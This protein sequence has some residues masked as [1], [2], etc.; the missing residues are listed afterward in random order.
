[1]L[2]ASVFALFTLGTLLSF[3]TAQRNSQLDNFANL[4]EK[5]SDR[6]HQKYCERFSG[7]FE[8][9]TDTLWPKVH[10]QCIENMVR[11]GENLPPNFPVSQDILIVF[12]FDSI[13]TFF[14]KIEPHI[15]E[16]IINIHEA[17][18]K[19]VKNPC[20][21]DDWLKVKKCVRDESFNTKLLNS[22]QGLPRN[23]PS[24]SLGL[25]SSIFVSF[26]NIKK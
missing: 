23:M 6:Q 20:K 19:I 5:M 16:R 18:S 8:A 12:I 15:R 21:D 3:T 14:Q 2:I 25:A 4:A 7:A 26:S 13:S 11:K 24:I 22:P 1:M 10:D 17:C 9:N